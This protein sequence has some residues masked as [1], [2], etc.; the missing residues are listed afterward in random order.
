MRGSLW[1]VKKGMY[2]AANTI[3]RPLCAK[4][5]PQ[6]ILTQKY[7]STLNKVPAMFFW[8]EGGRLKYLE[9]SA[10]AYYVLM[11]A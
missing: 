1:R 11:A 2:P 6:N 9:L 7:I 5:D 10:G 8:G 3:P 4:L